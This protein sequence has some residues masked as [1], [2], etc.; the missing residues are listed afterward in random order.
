[1]AFYYLFVLLAPFQEHPK[2]GAVLM[3]VG[4]ISITPIKLAGLLMVGAALLAADLPG[5]APRRPTAVPAL[6]GLFAVVPL[7]EVL[8]FGLPAPALSMAPLI[9]Y[10]FLM[11][12]TRR[13]VRTRERLQSVLRVLVLA[14]TIGSLWLYKQN[15][16]QHLSNPNGPSRDSNYEALSL[17]MTLPLASY[18]A[19]HDPNR[20]RRRI[21]QGCTPVLGFAVFVSQ[22]R[23]GVLALAA[24][25]A[26]GWL[27]S[28]RK[29]ATALVGLGALALAALC[30]PSVT[31]ER[32]HEIQLA[33]RPTTGAEMSTRTRIE[34]W[35]GGLRMIET[36]PLCGI[37]LDQFKSQVGY[38]NPALYQVSKRNYIAHNTYIHVAA[39][40][41][42]P[43]LAVFLAMI[44]LTLR[45]C[46]RA[47]REAR[48]ELLAGLASSMEL[49]LAAYLVVAMFLSAQLVKTLWIFVPLSQNLL[50]IVLAAELPAQTRSIG[51]AARMRDARDWRAA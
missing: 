9:S 19:R 13:L 29:L 8:V 26:L 30:A 27:R 22:S 42:L 33:G 37:G 20:S 47:Q 44:W 49:G 18:L 4:P 38:Y 41:G 31:W 6:Y 2:L 45:S 10:G 50:E 11:I 35:R 32:F 15:Y 16:I 24:L 28:R 17:V 51:V 40:E 14:E 1:M 48:D 43:V 7:A 39:E 36:H 25:S 12:A 21:S 3:S 5:A 46:R 34:L 23:G